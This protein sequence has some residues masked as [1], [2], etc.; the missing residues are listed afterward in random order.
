MRR[1]AVLVSGLVVAVCIRHPVGAQAPT[2]ERGSR[3]RLTLAPA[4]GKSL[5]G[6]VESV[7]E[8]SVSL[9]VAGQGATV[10]TSVPRA[11][12]ARVEVSRFRKRPMWS[13]SAPLWLTGTAGGIGALLGYATSSDNDFFGRGFGAAAGGVLGGLAGLLVGTGLALGVKVDQWEIV[14]DAAPESRPSRSPA[15][16]VGAGVRAA[17]LGLHVTF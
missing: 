12:I 4:P 16:H 2:L 15:V 3:V 14:A 11:R 6:D 9:R 17:R 10:M 13:K 7:T 8:D 1:A 5:V